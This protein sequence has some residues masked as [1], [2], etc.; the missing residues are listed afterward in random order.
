MSFKKKCILLDKLLSL[1]NN[2]ALP[3]EAKTI[4][5]AKYMQARKIFNDKSRSIVWTMDEGDFDQANNMFLEL[6]QSLRNL[7]AL[8]V[9]I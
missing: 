8:I 5:Y 9:P 1:S 3:R 7:D 6:K 2:I 4:G